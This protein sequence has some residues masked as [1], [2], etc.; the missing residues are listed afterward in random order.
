MT[1]QVVQITNSAHFG[2]Y[3]YIASPAEAAVRLGVDT[4]RALT[5]SAGVFSSFNTPLFP[6]CS[7]T[8]CSTTSMTTGI[9]AQAI[10]SAE[11][12]LNGRPTSAWWP[13]CCTMSAKLILA[14]SWPKEYADVL[15]AANR[16]RTSSDETEPRVFGATH[17]DVG[18]YLLWLWG[19]PDAICNA[20]A[21]PHKAAACSDKAFTAAGAIH[22]AD[23]LERER[24][25]SAASMDITYLTALGLADR[26]AE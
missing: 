26:V 22:I 1:A 3:R 6:Q 9:G 17:A 8:S 20:V 5:M 10:A 15:A 24:S 18:A 12:F 16:E 19:L 14:T 4:I 13:V 2:L 7:S 21:F 23:V 25:N 11:G